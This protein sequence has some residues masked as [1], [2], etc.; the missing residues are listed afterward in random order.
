MAFSR[1]NNTPIFLNQDSNYR[2]MF[3]NKR[4][5]QETYQYSLLSIRYPSLSAMS[6][7]TNIG[8][9]WGATDKLYNISNQ[10]YGAPNY[11]WIIAWYNKK[12]SEAEFEVGEIYYVPLP[13]EDLLEYF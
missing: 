9:V 3:F 4:D 6:N 12:G 5:I 11:W 8:L 13:L 10:Y 1:Y 2:N 7:L